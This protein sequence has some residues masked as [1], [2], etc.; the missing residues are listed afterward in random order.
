[1]FTVEEVKNLTQD[2]IDIIKNFFITYWDKGNPEWNRE[3]DNIIKIKQNPTTSYKK[4]IYYLKTLDIIA[5]LL[6][7]DKDIV[8]QKISFL[9][10]KEGFR[11]LGGSTE[12]FN[13]AFELLDTT[14]PIIE[15][16]AN[17]VE[18]FQYIIRKYQWCM[19]NKYKNSLGMSVFIMNEI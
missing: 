19:S 9:V 1:M 10:V 12:L 13:V 14:Y 6:I 18:Y 15:I 8:D 11:R 5:G 16:P 2:N 17:A 3:L 7:I 4:R